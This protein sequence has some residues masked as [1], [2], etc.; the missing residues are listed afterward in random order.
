MTLLKRRRGN[1]RLA[2]DTPSYERDK[3]GNYSIII[4]YSEVE[5]T[6]VL[7]KCKNICTYLES[8]NVSVNAGG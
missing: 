6:N 2:G 4:Q 5:R 7:T 1:S 3:R 8:S